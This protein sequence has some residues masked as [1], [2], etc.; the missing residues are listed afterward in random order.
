MDDSQVGHYW[1]E[2]AEVWTRLS[3]MGMDIYRDHFNTPAF[4][5]M[6]PDVKG[7]K[8]LDIGCGEGYNTRKVAELGARMTA[9]DIAPTFIKH[10]QE[11]EKEEPLGIDYLVASGLDLPFPDE[12]FDFAVA[13]MSLMDMC[14]HEKALREAYRVVKPGGFLQFSIC[15]PCFTTPYRRWVDG[16]KG[17]HIAMECGDYFKDT[18]GEI[19]E[20]I[21]HQTPPELKKKLKRFRIPGFHRTL[22]QWLNAVIEAGFVVEHTSEPT[23]SDE[24]IE[25]VPHLADTRIIAHYLIVRCCK[26]KG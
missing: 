12:S 20:W 6:L 17:R 23:A 10:A 21:F 11:K 26:P 5:S 18:K 22:S 16:S 7:L 24:A 25:K 19:S 3:R 2:N 13:F 14:D 1:E 9:I 4:L 15:H 8:G